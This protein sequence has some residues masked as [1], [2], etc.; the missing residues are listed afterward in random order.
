MDGCDA[1][2]EK[3]RFSDGGLKLVTAVDQRREWSRRSGCDRVECC[4][5]FFFFLWPRAMTPV[6]AKLL[7]TEPCPYMVIT[8]RSATSF[9]LA[10]SECA[11]RELHLPADVA[12]CSWSV[13]RK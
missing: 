1:V 3:Q 12:N 2:T 10:G 11:G 5:V 13:D 9:C 6:T 7:K 4:V 8:E